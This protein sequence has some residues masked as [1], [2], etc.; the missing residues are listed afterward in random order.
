[1]SRT[2]TSF[3]ARVYPAYKV[4]ALVTA[5]AEDGVPAEE[6]LS[7]TE[8][9]DSELAASRVS[10]RQMRTVIRNAMQL[11]RDP[12]L[13]FR[14]GQKMH[15]TATGMYGY[16]LLSSPSHIESI[17]FAVK[18]QAVMGPV[19]RLGFRQEQDMAIF[20][21]DP[22]LELDPAQDLYRFTMEFQF[23]SHLTLFLDLYGESFGF[24]EVRATYNAPA[25]VHLYERLFK[26]PVLFNQERDELRLA[27]RYLNEP[28]P[29]SHPIT[30]T[31][32]RDACAQS[33]AE[34][35]R[36][37]SL[38]AEVHRMLINHPGHFPDVDA[39]AAELSITERALRRR[40]DTEQTSYRKILT[41]VRMNL[42][43]EYLR[44]TSMTN[45]EI[46]ARLG[47]SDAAN[48]RRAF[49]RWTY[50]RPSDFRGR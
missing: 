1:V 14:A 30:N 28:M 49:S 38:A 40:L 35:S 50:K 32:A 19:A 39:M 21:Y 24:S 25:H 4:L 16:A 11:S 8:I 45:E 10:Y 33:L 44:K 15:F 18:Y 23:A 48:F 46:S 6:T 34:V 13:A 3:D 37:G 9:A 12:A 43:I 36:A 5:L 22:I 47:Y 41:E 31:I 2:P 27:A 26:C 42:A 7:G 29:L 20:S 17:D